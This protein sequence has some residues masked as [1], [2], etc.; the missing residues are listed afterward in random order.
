MVVSLNELQLQRDQI[1]TV[2]VNLLGWHGFHLGLM[3]SE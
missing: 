1:F 3:M 2:A